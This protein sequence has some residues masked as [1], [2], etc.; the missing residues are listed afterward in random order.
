M[1]AR[2]LGRFSI[3]ND[4]LINQP[5]VVA[6]M[7]AILKIIPVRA[8]QMFATDTIEYTA[9]SERFEEVLRGHIP[10]LYKFN[11]DQSEAGNVELVE[12]ERVV[13]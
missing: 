2:Q 12:V 6:E 3:T 10:P 1:N 9:I 13:E 4:M 8:E 5:E 11:I 7:F